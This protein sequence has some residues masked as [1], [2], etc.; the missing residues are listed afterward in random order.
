MANLVNIRSSPAPS[1]K[2]SVPVV[3]WLCCSPVRPTCNSTLENMPWKPNS[4]DDQPV[5]DYPMVTQQTEDKQPKTSGQTQGLNLLHTKNGIPSQMSTSSSRQSPSLT[6]GQRR[7]EGSMRTGQRFRER[8]P[9]KNKADHHRTA[10]VF[11][12]SFST[13]TT[14][15]SELMDRV[16]WKTTSVPLALWPLRFFQTASTQTPTAVLQ[17]TA[18]MLRALTLVALQLTF[19]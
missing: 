13:V 3:N 8:R 10:A 12:F 5:K 11:Y 19:L 16:T 4:L 7:T 1:P 15:H 2:P 14:P 9:F 17:K 18:A 6:S